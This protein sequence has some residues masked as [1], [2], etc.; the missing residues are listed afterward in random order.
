M[1][2]GTRGAMLL[3]FSPDLELDSVQGDDRRAAVIRALESGQLP[4][5]DIACLFSLVFPYKSAP[6][7]RVGF[8]VRRDDL[9]N[10]AVVDKNG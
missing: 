2:D 3:T 4:A 5:A 10:S 9:M 7:G 8:R 6:A 1:G